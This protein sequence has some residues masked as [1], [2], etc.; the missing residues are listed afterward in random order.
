MSLEKIINGI[1]KA[2]QSLKTLAY[3]AIIGAASLGVLAGN[4]EA[5]NPKYKIEKIPIPDPNANF[6]YASDINNDG[7]VVGAYGKRDGRTVYWRNFFLYKNGGTRKLKLDPNYPQCPDFSGIIN[8]RIN[9]FGDILIGRVIYKR[10]NNDLI[11]DSCDSY[12]SAINN[13]GDAVAYAPDQGYLYSEGQKIGL[14]FRTANAQDHEFAINDSKQVVGYYGYFW[15]NGVVTNLKLFIFP[16]GVRAFDINNNG[17]IVGNTAGTSYQACMWKDKDSDATFFG[18]KFSQAFGI[19][20]KEEIVGYCFVSPD[21]PNDYAFLYKDG[22]MESLNEFLPEDSE[23]AYLVRALDI[24]DKG[25]IIGYG[26]LKNE[27]GFHSAF[28]MMPRPLEGDLN[29]DG[30]VNLRDLSELVEH[31]LEER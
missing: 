4:T 1:R 16:G 17:V 29:N 14:G 25:Q 5:I 13:I 19:N 24:N 10:D 2:K 26:Y 15:E 30:I 6:I 20:D 31:W 12:W 8:P 22:K 27:K 11:L 7:E 18:P 3:S 28:L 23:W 21:Y 9:D